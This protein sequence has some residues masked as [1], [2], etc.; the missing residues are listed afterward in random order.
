MNLF[1][2]SLREYSDG[3]EYFFLLTIY[4]GQYIYIK[5]HNSYM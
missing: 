2:P 4:Y 5:G 1:H 3:F